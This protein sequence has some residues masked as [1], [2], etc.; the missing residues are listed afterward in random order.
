MANANAA[1]QRIR[2]VF[3]YDVFSSLLQLSCT[4]NDS[5][6]TIGCFSNFS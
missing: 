5:T 6:F 1:E 2:S 4:T 3:L